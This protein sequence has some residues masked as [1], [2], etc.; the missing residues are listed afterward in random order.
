M[1]SAGRGTTHRHATRCQRGPVPAPWLHRY[2]ET[3]HGAMDRKS[4]PQPRPA[5]HQPPVWP[6]P[7]ARACGLPAADRAGQP[8]AP[9]AAGEGSWWRGSQ[10][11]AMRAA[12]GPGWAMPSSDAGRGHT[13]PRRLRPSHATQMPAGT[14]CSQ[15]QRDFGWCWD[16]PSQDGVGSASVKTL[17]GRPWAGDVG[18]LGENEATWWRTWRAS[19][20]DL[21]AQHARCGGGRACARCGARAVRLQPGLEEWR[22]GVCRTSAAIF[23]PSAVSRRAVDLAVSPNV[24]GRN[25]RAT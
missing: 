18:R 21:H 4:P 1:P 14:A 11:P 19:V 15:V 9:C 17:G 12:R 22:L 2:K 7:A 13:A 16:R 10:A 8:V 6:C 3:N 23:V 5:R 24:S 20:C 25:K